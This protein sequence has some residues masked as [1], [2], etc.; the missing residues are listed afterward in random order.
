MQIS[1]KVSGPSVSNKEIAV[2]TSGDIKQSSSGITGVRGTT[3]ED[4]EYILP[5]DAILQFSYSS[6]QNLTISYL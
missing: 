5:W 6:M 4:K 1:K 2:T 3:T